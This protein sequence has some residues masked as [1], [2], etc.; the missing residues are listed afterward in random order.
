M[1]A[2]VVVTGVLV[3]PHALTRKWA[4]YSAAFTFLF[5]ST[6]VLDSTVEYRPEFIASV[7]FFSVLP[8]SCFYYGARHH[9][10]THLRTYAVIQV[11]SVICNVSQFIT[12]SL[13]LGKIHQI[14]Q[15]CDWNVQDCP[16]TEDKVVTQY[17][18]R[19]S[20]CLNIVYLV[21]YVV[22]TSINLKSIQSLQAS[23]NNSVVIDS[24]EVTLETIRLVP[25]E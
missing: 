7:F 2:T 23:S 15:D 4:S 21:L 1:A 22:M 24:T 11:L 6:M 16:Y 5:Y 25:P 17:W 10:K 19:E 13:Y 18:C 8:W 3:D 12:I 14:C 9:S 20:H